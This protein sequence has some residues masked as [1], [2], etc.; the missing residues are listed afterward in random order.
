LSLG[1]SGLPL[2][3]GAK[4]SLSAGLQLPLGDGGRRATDWAFGQSCRGRAWALAE[5]LLGSF[6][7]RLFLELAED[8]LDHGDAD[9]DVEDPWIAHIGQYYALG[10]RFVSG[11]V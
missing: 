6:L 8:P 1:E 4:L 9:D 7:G 3:Q 10:D 11:A 2:A 5:S